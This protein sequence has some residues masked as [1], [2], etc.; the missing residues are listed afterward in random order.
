[1]MDGFAAEFGTPEQYIVDIT[2][3][4][5]EGRSVGRIYDWYAPACPVRTP[6]GVTRSADAVVQGT[7]ETLHSF[8]D[9][10]LL[11]EDVI[12]GDRDTGFLSSHRVR[13]PATHRGD[14]AFGPA[15]QR[16]VVMLTVADCLCQENRIVDEWLVRDQAA[17]AAQIGIDPVAF[18]RKLGLQNP[19]AYTIGV[20][21]L[22][23]RWDDPAGLTICGDRD[24]GVEIMDLCHA[25]WNDKQLQI[26]AS[27]Y[28]RALRLEGPGGQLHYG[29]ER[30]TDLYLSLFASVP[31]GDFVAHHVI[32]RQQAARPV[33]VA[34]RWS[35]CGLHTGAG[36]FGPPSGVPLAL[37]GISHFELR[38]GVV[39]CEWMVVDETAIH[40]QIAAQQVPCQGS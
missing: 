21:A 27:K 33:R 3:Q 28:D 40:A 38:D 8:P 26:I 20:D 14:G 25:L 32:V 6:H 12:I 1:M 17:I 23:A 29:R 2:Y 35:Y 24:I 30:A 22:R 39:I 11:A 36:R 37:L 18:G 19:D 5:W 34:V 4:I 9:R 15:S 7:L 31:K 13:S 10:Q 16:Q